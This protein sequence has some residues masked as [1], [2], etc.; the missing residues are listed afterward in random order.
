MAL[1]EVPVIDSAPF[2]ASSPAERREVAGRVDEA[3]SD[4]G[5]LVVGGH[6]VRASLTA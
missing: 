6:D 5:F 1:L 2:A 3:R 4:I